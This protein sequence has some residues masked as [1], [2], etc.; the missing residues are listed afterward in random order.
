MFLEHCLS[1]A[2]TH[3]ALVRAHRAAELELVSV[4]TEPECWRP[5]TGLGGARLMLQPDLYVETGD[6]ADSAFVNC[7]FI[8]IDRGTENPARLLAKCGR[9]EAYRGTGREQVETGGFPLVVWVMREP[10]QAERLMAAIHQNSGLDDRL[11][12]VTTMEQLVYVIHGGPA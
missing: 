3:L 4:Q 12:R 2:D 8:E 11:Y 9:Y 10:Q 5:F 6:P 7:W 1:V